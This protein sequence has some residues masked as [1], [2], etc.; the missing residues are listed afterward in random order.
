MA[1]TKEGEEI[2]QEL[3]DFVNSVKGINSQLRVCR[4]LLL[5]HQS[6]L[7]ATYYQHNPLMRR[8][9]QILSGL[10][11]F[12]RRTPVRWSSADRAS[13]VND[14]KQLAQVSKSEDRVIRSRVLHLER[15]AFKQQFIDIV[16]ELQRTQKRSEWTKPFGCI[17]LVT[18]NLHQMLDVNQKWNAANIAAQIYE[19]QPDILAVQESLPSILEPLLKQFYFKSDRD[20]HLMTLTTKQTAYVFDLET[21]YGL[22]QAPERTKSV[23]F[24]DQPKDQPVKLSR[25]TLL[26]PR[27]F[28]EGMDPIGLDKASFANQTILLHPE[29]TSEEDYLGS[30]PAEESLRVVASQVVYLDEREDGRKNV[31]A[32]I[33]TRF[34]VNSCHGGGSFTTFVVVN[35]HLDLWDRS[36]KTSIVEAKI[37]L[38]KLMRFTNMRVEPVL[39]VGDLNYADLDVILAARNDLPEDRAEAFKL[40][41]LKSGHRSQRGANPVHAI[42][43][44]QGGFENVFEMQY[45]RFLSVAPAFTSTRGLPVD[46]ILVHLPKAPASLAGDDNCHLTLVNVAVKWTLDSDHIPLILDFKIES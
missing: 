43:K 30:K 1:D 25:R 15:K 12:P 26:K 19:L 44:T 17:R 3:S 27:T 14:E 33:F 36:G 10:R 41:D 28:P 23:T 38:Q 21:I 22:E 20:E 32:A 2:A 40:L 4:T 9:I 6:L 29:S 34:A 31:R 37:L 45:N 5:Q 46:H 8:Q 7:M 39:L 42:F 18:F 13:R 35:T 24:S 16:S 11:V